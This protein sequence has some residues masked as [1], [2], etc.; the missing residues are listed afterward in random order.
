MVIGGGIAGT[1]SAI[2]LRKAGHDAV[3]Y[4]AYDKTADQAGAFLTLAVNALDALRTLGVDIGDLGFDTPEITITSGSGRLLGR[5]PHGSSL[6]DGTTSRTVKR[7]DLYRTLREHA[8]R[9]GL[10]IEYGKRLVD[11]SGTGDGVRASFA[12]GTTA[13][14][15]LLIGADGL[16]SR[17]RHLI[18]PD[19]PE[20]RYTGLLTLG[21]Y[22]RGVT[23]GGEPGVMHA[24]FGKRCFFT[25]TTHPDGEVWW[26]ANPAQ[27]TEL[28]SPSTYDWRARLVELFRH[29]RGPALDIIAATDTFLPGWNTYD[30]PS[31]PRWHRDRMIIIGDAAHATAPSIG[32]GAAMA[33]E[34]TVVLATC[35]RD[36]AGPEAAFAAYERQ[37]RA[38]VERVVAQGNRT[39]GWK[40]LG[41]LAR[42]PR[43][44]VMRLAMSRM[45]KTGHDPSQ[46]IYD[47]HI[48][49]EHA[50]S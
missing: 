6:P 12:D 13:E 31:V 44:F 1:L 29:D 49:W 4:E 48:D 34:D 14:G 25:H 37:R 24:I 50:A 27:R 17:T 39:G 11:A 40:T 9:R 35:L 2:A 47:H 38:R 8:L 45:A 32:Q 30:I 21:G 19:A 7:A 41:P 28:T 46:W 20:A 10:R 22:A 18:D 16:R 42:V 23:T 15:D 3:I 43:D 26:A 36:A 5:L 33:I